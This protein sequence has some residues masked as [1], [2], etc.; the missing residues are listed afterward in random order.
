LQEKCAIAYLIKNRFEI[1]GDETEED[2]ENL[3]KRI[4]LKAKQIELLQKQLKSRLPKGRAW[5]GRNVLD[6]IQSIGVVE[7]EA[8]WNL[9]ESALLKQQTFLPHPILF[10]S[11]D[12]LIWFEHERSCLKNSKTGNESQP[13]SQSSKRVCVRF[14]SFDEKYAFEISGDRRHLRVLQ[15]ALKERMVYD[16]DRNGNTSKLFL[17]RSATLIWKEYKKNENRILRRRKA[18]NKRSEREGQ[19]IINGSED[20]FAPEFYNPEFP[21]NRYQL[22][23][24]CTVETQ[25]LSQEG[26][27]LVIEK[28]RK[29]IV[30]AL[31]TLEERIAESEEKG[32]SAQT[33]KANYS[34]QTGTLRRLDSYDNNY[35]RPSQPL[36]VGHSHILTGVALGSSGLVTATIADATSSKFLDC[37]GLK[38]LLGNNYRLV[39]RRQFQRQLNSRR[40]TE[41]Q[42]RGASSQFGE[43]NLGDTI[44]QLTAKSVI[45]FAKEH[46]SGCIVLPDMKDYRARQQSGIAALAE[47]ECSGWKGVEKQFAKAQ[48][49]KIHS[50]SYGR[51]IRYIHNQA[52]KEGISVKIGQQPIYGSS[53]EQAGKMAIDA[54]Q[55]KAAPKKTRPK[56]FPKQ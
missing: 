19:S 16:S 38:A 36:Y 29:P 9:V 23:L 15:Q 54:Y 55:D 44:D 20:Q 10:H 5:V 40:R 13:N 22:F 6:E 11:S 52:Q 51:L 17:V 27:E 43:S 7:D 30:K 53:Q 31:E 12:D 35:E 42:K 8:E 14:K 4:H 50:W 32:E 39:H 41:A 46:H 49:M 24:H 25:F 33:R 37:R 26:T 48:N 45:D 21:W 56:N 3:S 2:L 47:R 18:R 1:K 28:R 34:R